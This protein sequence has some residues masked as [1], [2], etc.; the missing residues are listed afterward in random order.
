MSKPQ[1]KCVNKQQK[2]PKPFPPAC[3]DPGPIQTPDLGPGYLIDER[4]K[5]GIHTFA[6]FFWKLALEEQIKALCLQQK[7]MRCVISQRSGIARE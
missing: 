3:C 2:R 5:R 1:T 7:N 4:E 6:H